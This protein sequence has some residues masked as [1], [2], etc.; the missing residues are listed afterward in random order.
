MPEYS[1]FEVVFWYIGFD[2]AGRKMPLMLLIRG[3]PVRVV[4]DSIKRLFTKIRTKG[5]P[6]RTGKYPMLVTFR[7]SSRRGSKTNYTP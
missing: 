3:Y 7:C 2:K 5:C 6:V 4:L 1:V